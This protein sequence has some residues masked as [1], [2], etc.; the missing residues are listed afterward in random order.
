MNVDY[1]VVG[2]YQENCYIVEKEGHYLVIDPG[3]RYDK[4]LAKLPE[5]VKADAILLTHGH[6][7]HIGAVDKLVKLWHCPVYVSKEDSFMVRDP[8]LNISNA[9]NIVVRSPLTILDEGELV[10]GPFT[11]QVLRT[12]GH[13]SGSVVFQIENALFTGDTLFHLSVGRTDLPSGNSS[14]LK[15]SLAYLKTLDPSFLI[16][17]GH[18]EFSTLEEEIFHN[19]YL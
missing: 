16:Y 17:P 10:I 6:V 2:I 7:D 11:I 4:I 15:N 8:Y 3:S 1:V 13:T 9:M 18:D 5:G 14:E 19:P 12:P